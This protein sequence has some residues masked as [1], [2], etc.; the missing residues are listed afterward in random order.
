MAEDVNVLVVGAGPTGLLLAAEL[1]RRGVKVRIIDSHPAPLHWDRATVIHPRSLEIFESLDILEPLLAEGVRQRAVRIHS[2]GRVLG[3]MDLT[4]CGSRYG[5]NIGISEEVTE[6]ILGD[7][8]EQQ[9]GEVLRVS[10]LADLKNCGDSVLATIQCHGR[11]QQVS[12]QWV[13]GCDGYHS[14]VRELAGIA[15]FGHDITD[16]WAVFDVTLAGWPQSYEVTY[17]YLE[18]IP[19]ILTSLP[20]RRW[21]VYVR[22]SCPDSDLVVDAASTIR[23]YHPNV[24]F[25]EVTHPSR[26]NCHAKVAA[27]FRSGRILLAGDAAHVCSPAQGHGMNSGL[28][29]AVN[30]AWKLALVCQGHCSPALLD[31][32]EAERHPVAEQ[33]VASGEAAEAL[34]SERTEA[35]R[36]TR[37]EM[38]RT[39]F[40]DPATRHHE[41]VAEAELD[42][43][44]GESPIVLGKPHDSL[45]PGQR[46]PDTIEMAEGEPRLLHQMAFRAG[47]TALL[48]GGSSAIHAQLEEL[49]S[50]ILNHR[51]AAL[52]EET[53]VLTSSAVAG[54]P[55]RRISQASADLMGICDMTLLVVRPDGYLGLRADCDHLNAF[56]AYQ[57]RLR[58]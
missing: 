47:H 42:I 34:Q 43:H 58:E 31:T 7:Y 16:P 1:N 17:A 26:F 38:L 12:A 40:A 41:T 57:M 39:A 45:G 5:F 44:Y 29:D 28:Q 14:A 49:Y 6:T 51:D 10:T 15:M 2:A 22:P 19:T 48:I 53:F 36:S 52:I 4:T 3:E 56:T 30:L 33:I 27:R 18:E 50:Q 37:D 13:V 25:E 9:G 32:F 54:S 55:Q 23:H 21:R 46:F 35:E 8:L 11:E 24:E 20:Q